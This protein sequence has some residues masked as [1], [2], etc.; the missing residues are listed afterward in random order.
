MGII[1]QTV[2]VQLEYF[3]QYRSRD[4]KDLESSATV[5][6]NWVNVEKF[7]SGRR[8]ISIADANDD[9]V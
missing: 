4:L 6:L 5:G 9:Q 7:K 8:Q 1:D 2:R 3:N